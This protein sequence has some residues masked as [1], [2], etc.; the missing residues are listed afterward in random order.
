MSW[1]KL[2]LPFFK[3]AL[4]R[5]NALFSKTPLLGPSSVGTLFGTFFGTFLS[6]NRQ[7]TVKT[8]LLPELFSEF[9]KK[10]L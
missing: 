10:G 2:T 4:F 5:K 3:N 6:K 9:E 8:G 7:K 1:C